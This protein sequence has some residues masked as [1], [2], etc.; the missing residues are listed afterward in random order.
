MLQ[1]EFHRDSIKVPEKGTPARLDFEREWLL[2]HPRPAG[3]KIYDHSAGG[4]PVTDGE[5]QY[6]ILT[7]ANS[8]SGGIRSGAKYGKRLVHFAIG[9]IQC[10]PNVPSNP[11]NVKWN[12]QCSY[13]LRWVRVI[14]T[15]RIQEKTVE[16]DTRCGWIIDWEPTARDIVV[17]PLCALIPLS[18]CY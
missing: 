18:D 17:F 13:T 11:S 6:G 15:G 8:V 3:Y 2:K 9:Q 10:G 14:R 7:H 12:S 4:K 5:K 1:T 16:R